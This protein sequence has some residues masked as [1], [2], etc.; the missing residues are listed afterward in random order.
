MKNY[1]LSALIFFVF[2]SISF[3]QFDWQWLN[4][5]PSGSDI[6]DMTFISEKEGFILT[7]NQLLKTD[8]AGESWEINYPV[9]SPVDIEF[10]GTKGLIVEKNA[11]HLTLDKGKTWK[12][13][14]ILPSALIYE[15][16]HTAIILS[17]SEIGFS[18]SDFIYF[19]ADNGTVWRYFSAQLANTKISKVYFFTDVTGLLLTTDG[20]IY[21]TEDKGQNWKLTLM[22]DYVSTDFRNVYFLNDKV[23]Y[24]SRENNSIIKTIDGG[25]TWSTI[26]NLSV[27]INSFSFV[28]ENNGFLASGDG[29][30][31]T[32][33]DGG[34]TL[35]M[36]SITG[37]VKI[38]I[39]LNSIYFLNK[40][41]GFAGGDKGAIFKTTDGGKTWQ[42][43]SL[44]ANDI[45][46]ITF[47]SSRIG[48]FTSSSGKLY[49]TQDKGNTW[50][51]KYDFENHLSQLRFFSDDKGV[52]VM[53]GLVYKTEDG[54]KTWKIIKPF[55][56]INGTMNTHAFYFITETTWAASA[57]FNNSVN[58]FKITK[59]GGQNWNSK[60]S[61]IGNFTKLHFFDTEN[62][63]GIRNGDL[64][65]TINSGWD[66]TLLS[67]IN[68]YY[69][70]INGVT[71]SVAYV[72][73]NGK[74]LLRT[75]NKG[76]TWKDHVMPG[77]QV[78]SIFF[79]NENV[80]FS[81][82]LTGPIYYTIDGGLSWKGTDYPLN[83]GIS[84]VYAN[85]E[86]IYCAGPNGMLIRSK[87]KIEDY[88]VKVPLSAENI[89]CFDAKVSGT[90][91]ANYLPISN[92]KLEYGYSDESRMVLAA[93]ESTLAPNSSRNQ[94][95]NIKN[96]KSGTKY[97]FF[98]SFDYN[99]KRQTS[100]TSYF[101]TL[102]EVELF[103]SYEGSIIGSRKGKFKARVISN[104]KS[105]T[106]IAIEYGK[107]NVFNEL[108]K[109]KPDS[110]QALQSKEIEVE[111]TGL[112]PDSSYVTRLRV[113][114]N[115]Q[116]FFS[117]PI[118]YYKT[119]PIYSLYIHPPSVSN[120]IVYINGWIR[121]P[122]DSIKNIVYEYDTTRLFKTPKI[123]TISGIK[124]PTGTSSANIRVELSNLDPEKLYYSRLK[125]TIGD[126]IVY[127]PLDL[128]S[129][130]QKVEIIPTDIEFLDSK[131]TILKA[132]LYT[133]WNSIYGT[134]FLYG[135]NG[136]L[137]DSV[138]AQS[139]ESGGNY[140]VTT[141]LSA[142]LINLK[143][144]T[145][146][147]GQF[148]AITSSNTYL[149]KPFTFFNG[150]L[151]SNEPEN[152]SNL[153]IYP[154]PTNDF[155]KI[156]TPDKIIKKEIFKTD[157]A[158]LRQITNDSD[159]IDI[160]DLPTG[161]Y[162]LRVSTPRSVVSNK[163]IRQ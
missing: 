39:S 68:D 132:L 38:N 119:L 63:I 155:I 26:Q 84:A 105:V 125:F 159:T 150:T 102:Q 77:N 35:Y 140:F 47:S 50:A 94:A 52:V 163:V 30:I 54:G 144:N 104:F 121:V 32:T 78:K 29:L 5:K 90:V 133:G 80:G 152:K 53:N 15:T 31:N 92:I 24:A 13:L 4:P 134:K 75:T 11:V 62:G 161:L 154:N 98:I 42:P 66:W 124:G 111:L 88:G 7:K 16:S 100:D 44:Y 81:A 59:D 79:I 45:N 149:S 10:K 91:F 126:E 28:D 95:F 36:K 160:A 116:T 141:N 2:H 21:K 58:Y 64:Y 69:K 148:K 43:Y 73:S 1:L 101:R 6:I 48:Y 61:D 57:T 139:K 33:S 82:G 142:V 49:K 143:P 56:G 106:D 9:S 71:D 37:G 110:V 93:S 157:G 70:D 86:N 25:E 85:S 96:L 12:K 138:K 108:T 118:L 113:K 19:S 60:T 146:Y 22:Q 129:L 76:R 123:E 135:E 99:G 41:I 151:L 130:T 27:A 46:H 87:I 156:I 74:I 107:N 89:G 67:D 55:D 137:T 128:F 153:L 72:S 145:Y 40:N 127:G 109:A 14:D 162:I 103:M 117:D 23:G 131:T 34:K 20:R 97:W 115:N 120:G 3:A 112:T 147:K 8:N 114:S 65:K 122:D 158:L 83:A 17:D 51:E 18:D 136:V